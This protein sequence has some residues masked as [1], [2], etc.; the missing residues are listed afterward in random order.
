MDDKDLVAT[1]VLRDCLGAYNSIIGIL[2]RCERSYFAPALDLLV[3]C[4]FSRSD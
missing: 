4:Y 3:N 1:A 2:C